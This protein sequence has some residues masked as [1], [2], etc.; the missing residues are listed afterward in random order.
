MKTLF[1]LLSLLSILTIGC[2][3]SSLES[4]GWVT[5]KPQA[6]KSMNVTMGGFE[7]DKQTKSIKLFINAELTSTPDAGRFVRITFP[8]G[9][10]KKPGET[11][12]LPITK[13]KDYDAVSG[14]LTGL[15]YYDSYPV[16]IQIT[17]DSAG[18]QVLEEITQYVRFEL[19]PAIQAQ[20]GLKN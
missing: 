16:I 11:K 6:S 7:V 2:S 15:K 4:G 9:A 8:V 5:P 13:K 1:I 17:S 3:T 19:H 14:P 10:T 12:V 20:L 18:S